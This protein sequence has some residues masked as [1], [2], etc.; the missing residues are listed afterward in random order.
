[1]FDVGYLRMIPGV[2]VMQ[3][4][5][6]EELRDMLWTAAL[7]PGKAP[8]AVRYPRTNVP[9][10]TLPDREPRILEIGRA[11][12]LRAGGDVA[13]VA[14]GTMVLPALAAA[15]AL[16]AK[17][18]SATVVNARFASPLDERMIAGLARSIGRI[19]TV[20]ENVIAG[21]F[22]SAVSEAL[23]RLG[24]AGT[25]LLRLG[26]PDQFVLHG[27]RDEL[28]AQCGLD[29]PGIARRTSDWI[30]VTQPLGT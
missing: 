30:Q 2:V 4:K 11:E 27:K 29:A 12:Q 10:E 23:D 18:V 3:P 13:I 24:L 5:N 6:G 9:D 21:G 14:L 16:A 15:E 25:P 22:G 7:W 19:V 28:L 8:I 1:V 17:G 20:E 26:V